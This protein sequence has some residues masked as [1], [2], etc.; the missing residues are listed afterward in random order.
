MMCRMCRMAC[1]MIFLSCTCL[2]YIKQRVN[3]SV[4][5]VQD[6]TRAR[7]RKKNKSYTCVC[8]N[9]QNDFCFFSPAR[10]ANLSCTPAHLM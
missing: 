3:A 10:E 7:T 8:D 2:S 1:R 5:D 4:Q 6:F 9:V